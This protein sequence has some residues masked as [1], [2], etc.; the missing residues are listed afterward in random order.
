MFRT[1]FTSK[2]FRGSK[3]KLL[4]SELRSPRTATI[5]DVTSTAQIAICTT[6]NMSRTVIR[7]R[8]DVLDPDLTISYGSVL[9][10]WRTGARPKRSPLT[11][12]RT[13]ATPYT[14]A[15][16]FTGI[17]MGQRENG[18]QTLS[19]SSSATPAARPTAPPA[20]EISKASVNNVRKMRLR[21]DPSASRSAISRVRSAA[22]AANKLPRFAHAANR[23]KPA[24]NINAVM[25][26]RTGRPR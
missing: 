8:L 2:A 5:D 24:S 11:N 15:S 6:S 12:A 21:L 18:C 14:F 22:R 25:N 19:H 3:P 23:I 13:K 17:W 10:T 20:I 4:P 9:S 7:R 1:V 26:A 16:G